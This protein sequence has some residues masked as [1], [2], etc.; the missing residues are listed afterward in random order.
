[1]SLARATFAVLFQCMSCGS[2]RARR[3][4]LTSTFSC[5]GRARR[6]LP[7]HSVIKHPSDDYVRALSPS[8]SLSL[9]QSM[10]K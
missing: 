5:L 8:L 1:M 2:K 10:C 7:T 6:R 9:S 3:H 4:R